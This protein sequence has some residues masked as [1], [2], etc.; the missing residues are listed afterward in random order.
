MLALLGSWP[1]ISAAHEGR[2][3]Y[4]ELF[5][6][7]PLIYELKWK[8]PPVM[9]PGQEPL[10]SL[11]SAVCDLEPG[12][13]SAGQKL[14]GK[15]RYSCSQKP[16]DLAV[17]IDYPRDNPALSSLLVVSDPSGAQHNVFADPQTLK[18]AVPDASSLFGVAKQYTEGGVKHILAGWDHLLF[19]LCLL[20]LAGSLRRILLTVTGFT[21]AHTITLV[22]STLEVIAVPIVFVEML[23]ALSIVILAA[24]IINGVVRNRKSSLS[25]KHPFYVACGFGLVHGFGFASVLGEFGLPPAMKSSA[26]IFFNLG[27][28]LG[29]IFFILTALLVA[30]IVA[31]VVTEKSRQDSIIMCLIYLA[32]II[33]SYWLFER[34]SALL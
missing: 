22:L 5:I 21:L 4:L 33:A 3:V 14:V 19:V 16:K 12:L 1:S 31:R 28:E 25:W 30:K 2:P 6:S 10:I 20:V 27:I 26:L 13:S 11:Q 18:I 9:A 29:Q 32:G 7:S 24:E 23:I 15:K 17:L 34:F 8:I